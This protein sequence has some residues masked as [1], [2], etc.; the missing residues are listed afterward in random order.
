MGD[1]MAAHVWS[2]GLYLSEAASALK[3]T[4]E[5]SIVSLSN[6]WQDGLSQQLSLPNPSPEEHHV[7]VQPEAAILVEQDEADE[8]GVAGQCVEFRQQVLPVPEDRSLVQRRV[9]DLSIPDECPELSVRSE[10]AEELR[11]VGVVVS[12]RRCWR[13]YDQLRV[14]QVLSQE[15]RFDGQQLAVPSSVVPGVYVHMVQDVRRVVAYVG[16]VH[17]AVAVHVD[18]LQPLRCVTHGAL[19]ARGI[20]VGQAAVGDTW[21]KRQAWSMLT[22]Q[23]HLTGV[24]WR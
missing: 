5:Q 10:G 2:E 14:V 16:A 6:T 21:H 12:G 4:Y 1:V 20:L 15:V 9:S 11:D 22:T 3:L 17:T 18:V 24:H 8:V 7:I 13:P 19:Q 23:Q